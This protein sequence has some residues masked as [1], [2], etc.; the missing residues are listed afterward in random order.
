MGAR[1]EA[2]RW[3]C[4]LA[5]LSFLVAPLA[6]VS[7]SRLADDGEDDAPQDAWRG[8]ARRFMDADPARSDPDGFLDDLSRMVGAGRSDAA[9]LWSAEEGLVTTATEVLDEYRATGVAEL[10]TSGYLDMAGNVW[11]A[12]LMTGTGGVDVVVATCDEEDTES[13]VRVVRLSAGEEPAL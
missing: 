13:V 8:V 1:R 11:G 6:I 3:L 5:F 9:V 10:V 7:C 12:I 4:M 2:A